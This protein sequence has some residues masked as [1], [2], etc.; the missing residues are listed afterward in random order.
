M[1][2]NLDREFE[3]KRQKTIKTALIFLVPFLGI[4]AYLRHL[5]VGKDFQVLLDLALLGGALGSLTLL[6]Y[7]PTLTKPLTRGILLV[8]VG[9]FLLTFYQERGNPETLIWGIT[10][11]LIAFLLRGRHEGWFWS[12]LTIGGP[13]TLS[14]LYPQH[15]DALDDF[16]ILT[17]LGN[18]LL[19]AFFASWYEY[20]SE[21]EL[22][23]IR[24]EQ[25]RLE[26]L[27]RHRTRS[28]NE[29]NAK[30]M[31]AL[32]KAEEANAA[33]STFLANV[34]HE[35]RTPLNAINGFIT[36]MM[37]EESDPQ[38]RKKLQT[39]HEA[40]DILTQLISD[41]LDLSKIESG[42]MELNY[43]EFD[44]KQLFFSVAELYQNRAIEKHIDLRIEF[45]AK[46]DPVEQVRSD[47]MRIRQVL[48]NLL[49]NAIKFT[50]VEGRII[51]SGCYRDGWLHFS[52]EDTG[53]GMTPADQDRIFKPFQQAANRDGNIQGT[54]LG[55]TISRE[56]AQRL[57]GKLEV[58]SAP[59]MGS[60][61]TFAVPAK[62]VRRDTTP[63]M[64]EKRKVPDKIDAHVL[65]VED[66]RANQ[67]FI[68]MVLDR[69]GIGYDLANDGVEAVEQFQKNRYDLILMDENMPRMTGI[70]ATEAI[71]K[72][73]RET[74]REPIPIVALT[75]NAVVGDRERFIAAGMNE[76]ITK[77]VNPELL[78][79]TI[80][81]LLN[82]WE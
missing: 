55:L 4:L 49:S 66:V 50:P 19:V 8:T 34:S 5:Q 37:N 65:V 44:P 64:A 46:G 9:A 20:L 26:S 57:Q 53:I 25:D 29:A 14:I 18:A 36:M 10:V 43:T 77:P 45:C 80:A 72:I 63:K 54:G 79:R 17:F 70:E 3:A 59:G 69:Y 21:Q 11:I 2:I 81:T 40:S 76:Y 47:P 7:F 27:V 62:R 33:K 68:T 12:L 39:I 16:A 24:H 78:G 23:R 82:C 58:R 73:E 31:R 28:L 6:H 32:K 60:T 1:P 38:K 71:R 52:V 51:V 56:I 67:M 61:F 35:I 75:A 74:S 41:I 15:L 13:L 30:A 48:N 42:N 22:Q